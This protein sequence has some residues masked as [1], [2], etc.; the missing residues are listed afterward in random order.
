MRVPL[1]TAP[2]G[3]LQCRIRPLNFVGDRRVGDLRLAVY[4]AFLATYV[5]GLNLL[6]KANKDEGWRVPL[7][8]VIRVWRNGSIIRSDRIADVLQPVYEKDHGLQNALANASVANEIKRTYPA[9]KRTV[10]RGL[11]WDTHM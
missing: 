9:L 1:K 2:H 3:P 4:C 11:E 10:G 8:E 5:Q 6:S 7:G